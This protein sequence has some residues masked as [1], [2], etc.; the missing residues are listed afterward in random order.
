MDHGRDYWIEFD[1]E[2]NGD[3][4][5]QSTL[6]NEKYFIDAFIAYRCTVLISFFRTSAAQKLTKREYQKRKNGGKK[7]STTETSVISLTWN[8]IGSKWTRMCLAH[9]FILRNLE[10]NLM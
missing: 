10:A 7:G 4:W 2:I 3:Q 1:A 8:A 5:I 9:Y 6:K